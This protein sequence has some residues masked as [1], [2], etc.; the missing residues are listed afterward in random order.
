LPIAALVLLGCGGGSGGFG[1]VGAVFGRDNET[2]DLYVREVVEG[3]GAEE[4][5]LSP[6]DQ[7]VMIDGVFVRD[8][9]PAA[10]RARL[11]GEVGTTVALTVVHGERVLRVR[12]QRRLPH[13]RKAPAQKEERI[14]E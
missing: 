14:G 4:A 3:Q 1:T 12:V 8:L 11:R 13:A 9:D 5:G 10:I 7:V 2:R 6:G